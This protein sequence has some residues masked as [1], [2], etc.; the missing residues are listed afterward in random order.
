MIIN[1]MKK[2]YPAVLI[3]AMVLLLGIG[4]VSCD[5]DGT[6]AEP[7][8]TE[9]NGFYYNGT[10][11]T[12]FEL[13]EVLYGSDDSYV[14]QLSHSTIDVNG[15][16]RDYFEYVAKAYQTATPVVYI[17]IPNGETVENF[18]ETSGWKETAD[19]NGI[20]LFFAEA[21]DGKWD[22]ENDLLLWDELRPKDTGQKI[23]ASYICGYAEGA[24]MVQMIALNCTDVFSGVALIGPSDLEAAVFEQYGNELSNGYKTYQD[25]G[26]LVGNDE[27]YVKD[28][29]EN[30]FIFSADASEISNTIDFW[31]NA[32]KAGDP[33]A[34]SN[35]DMVYTGTQN[36]AA[37][38]VVA[39]RDS[40]TFYGR[41]FSDE[42]WNRL[43]ETRRHRRTPDG[44]LDF[45]YKWEENPNATRKTMKIGAYD[46]EWIE[47]LPSS[48]LEGIRYPVILA[49][50]GS[51]QDGPLMYDISGLWD[52]AESENVI[53]LCPSSLRTTKHNT[54]NYHFGTS[55]DNGNGMQDPDFLLALLDKYEA[56]GC[57]DSSRVYITGFSNGGH[58]AAAMIKMYPERFAAGFLY[59]GGLS[60][61]MYSEVVGVDMITPMWG[62]IGTI[63]EVSQKNCYASMSRN[64]KYWAKVNHID[65]SV[66]ESTYVGINNTTWYAGDA[67]YV[68]TYRD[69]SDH[70]M[71]FG[72]FFI[73][74]DEMFSHCQ[75]GEN[76]E[77]IWN[78]YVV[79]ITVDGN[80]TQMANAKKIDGVVYLPVE[81]ALK[82]ISAAEFKVN[83]VT[84]DGMQYV[85][86][87]SFCEG[88]GL[89]SSVITLPRSSMITVVARQDF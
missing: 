74:W 20:T 1:I 78:N 14:P 10:E 75:R 55:G 11:V 80:S 63:E 49:L 69:N 31:K 22:R 33:A 5:Y 12:A 82:A 34:D 54:W 2:F 84:Y 48:Y 24:E 89:T 65:Q 9:L 57:I 51:G 77:S 60:G 26:V 43:N 62:T 36:S 35:G 81:D 52:L 4:A 85:S 56:E 67:P 6:A 18:L 17:F 37:C 79:D 38:V 19:A 16:S 45:S 53:V 25:K 23:P 7:N 42:I 8:R 40:D 44:S 27:I 39:E 58:M 61:K 3:M 72:D 21:N 70:A 76:G 68:Q 32:N 66:T 15:V 50:H 46:R 87:D 30:V 47:I 64:L 13:N 59:S 73:V 83:A 29:E 88:L 71:H 41:S 86:A 28:V